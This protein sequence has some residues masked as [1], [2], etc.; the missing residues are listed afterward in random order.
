NQIGFGTLAAA[1]V[2]GG[3]LQGAFVI[4]AATP[5]QNGTPV[6]SAFKL[7]TTAVGTLTGATN[8][9]QALTTYQLLNAGANAPTDNVLVTGSVTKNVAT[10]TVN[11]ILIV[12]S[13][14]INTSAATNL[15][16][17]SGMVAATGGSSTISLATLTLSN[18]GTFIT[19]AGATNTINTPIA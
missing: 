19:N 2:I 9:I 11:S 1:N 5:L 8:G 7:G 4:D 10:D 17:T 13:P 18:E 6:P 16:V 3:V 12:G 15:T 14:T